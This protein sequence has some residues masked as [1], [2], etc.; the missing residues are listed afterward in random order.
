[1]SEGSDSGS[2]PPA[3]EDLEDL[4]E[5]APCG[6]L[7]L[8]PRGHIVKVN[9]TLARWLEADR[10]NL[11]GRRFQE[12]LSIAGAMFYETHFAPLLRMQGYFHE[13]AFDLKK[14]DGTALATLA[15][16]AERRD[17][18]G[19]L[20]FTRVTL[21]LA[22]D[23]RRYERQLVEARRASEQ[24]RQELE[25]GLLA[26]RA[27]AELR[28]QFMAVLGHD[29][30]NP[31]AALDAGTKV[32]QR[33]GALTPRGADVVAMMRKS[34]QRMSSLIDDVLDLARSRMGGGI[35]LEISDGDVAETTCQVVEELRS[36][37]PEREVNLELDVADRPPLDHD[38][39]AQLMSNLLGNAI[40][41]GCPEEPVR[42]RLQVANRR[43]V[44]SVSN[45]GSPIPGDVLPRLFQPFYRGDGRH[46]REGLGLGL[47]IASEIA[48]AHGGRIDVQSDQ[49][50]TVFT[51][52]MDFE[53]SNSEGVGM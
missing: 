53:V 32:L 46:S 19:R 50:A 37:H 39:Y 34:I 45:G 48:R 44:L 3:L 41:H 42:C 28:E 1:M 18:N 30:R 2:V 6:Y 21:F 52:T 29:L 12:L 8:D 11:L 16:A 49:F 20:L 7:S 23:R 9:A 24:M 14:P 40:K 10:D 43:L 5:N 17:D 15:N 47:F 38:R 25:Q 26:E 51:F 35:E 22:G 31:L 36:A 27:T 13:V 4:Y 33:E